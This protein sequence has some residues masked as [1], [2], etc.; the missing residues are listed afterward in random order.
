MAELGSVGEMGG[1]GE[2]PFVDLRGKMPVCAD[3]SF[4]RY[5]QIKIITVQIPVQV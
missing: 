1:E 4:N 5:I 3:I 2:F